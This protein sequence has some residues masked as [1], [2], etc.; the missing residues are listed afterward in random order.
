MAKFEKLA[1]WMDKTDRGQAELARDLGIPKQQSKIS[2]WLNLREGVTPD[3]RKKL[4]ELGFH[5][6]YPEVS[7]DD[8]TVPPELRNLR[9]YNPGT[10]A[11][12]AW[13]IVRKA[14]IAAGVDVLSPNEKVMTLVEELI[15]SI[16]DGVAQGG[17]EA[18]EARLLR[19]AEVM[20]QLVKGS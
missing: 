17:E 5:G 11:R 2:K 15:D 20:L 6:P 12:R 14:A 3:Y 16:A 13:A 18:G 9:D 1:D 8:V 7:N 19:K 4:K 10:Y